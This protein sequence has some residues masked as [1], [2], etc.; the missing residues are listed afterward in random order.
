MR[1]L[2]LFHLFCSP[3]FAEDYIEN[4]SII[5]VVKGKPVTLECNTNNDKSYYTC[6]WN[7][8]SIYQDSKVLAVF[9]SY[10]LALI[11]NMALPVM[12]FQ[13]QG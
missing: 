2:L 3:I 12:E 5:Y 7:R 8:H 10:C 1:L 11:R 4:T 9:F 6:K 13:D